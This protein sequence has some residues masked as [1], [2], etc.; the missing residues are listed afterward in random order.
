M[1]KD[2]KYINI[3]FYR[4]WKFIRISRQ[5]KEAVKTFLFSGAPLLFNRL[6]SYQHWKN[7]QIFSIDR[8]PIHSKKNSYAI[9]DSSLQGEK[10][11]TGGPINKLAVVVH[12]FY[13]DVFKEIL[14]MLSSTNDPF[15][16]LF[17]TCPEYLQNEINEAIK[18]TSFAYLVKTVENHGRD[19]LPFLKILPLVFDEGFDVVLKVHTKRS[20]HLNKKELWQTDLFYKLLNKESVQNIINIFEQY[21]QVG[22]LGPA[23]HILPMSLYYG[24]NALVVG[25]LCK[26]MGL[27]Q[28]QLHNLNFV[29][30]SMFYARKEALLPVLQLGLGGHDFE[31]E[32]KQLDNTMAHAVERVFGAGLIASGLKLVDSSSNQKSLSCQITLN[33]PFTI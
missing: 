28:H 4:I 7:S 3:E 22:M 5:K 2:N 19:V 24:G 30:G 14:K 9:V 8:K 10:E 16:K 6:A 20:N 33:H 29:A 27:G 13:L 1:Q 25:K 32:D 11:K 31:D 23:G 18:E 17:I 12:V 26:K 21:P 15:I